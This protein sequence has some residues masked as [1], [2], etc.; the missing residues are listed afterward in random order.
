MIKIKQWWEQFENATSRKLV[1][2]R[3]FN[4]A[5]GNDS[6]GYR[7]L[8]R[9]GSKGLSAF[10]TFQALCQLM[11]AL[12]HQAR[13]QG[14]MINSNGSILDIDDLSDLTRVS[15]KVLEANIGILIEIGWVERLEP[16][17]L[18]E[19]PDDLPTPPDDLPA[20][21]RDTPNGEEGRGEDR[22]GEEGI[23]GKGA[24]SLTLPFDSNEF[25][26]TWAEW[27]QHLKEMK[28]N[29][30]PSAIKKQLNKLST[31]TEN[32]AIFTINK[33]ITNNWQGI[34][35]DES[36]NGISN[37]KSRPANSRGSKRPARHDGGGYAE[38][39][40]DGIK[41]KKIELP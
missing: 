20:I 27:I 14:S 18:K 22:R 21:Y 24:K 34:F 15:D 5:S 29:P 41:V 12:G 6:R 10:G 36:D 40:G 4:S 9:M 3:H 25:A 13:K 2:I 11:A 35:P 38:N 33:S 16:L 8:M 19:S 7:K 23:G 30:T 37:G 28:K 39:A 17:E 32:D 31:L 1:T 26:K